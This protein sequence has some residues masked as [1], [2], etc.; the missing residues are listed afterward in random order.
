M[1]HLTR[2]QVVFT[3][4]LFFAWLLLLWLGRSG[5]TTTSTHEASPALT[6]PASAALTK[7]PTPL[8]QPAPLIEVPATGKRVDRRELVQQCLRI[9]ETDVLAAMDFA[10]AQKLAGDDPGLLTAVILRWA[11]H[12]FAEAL[13][14]VQ[15]QP[16]SPA[17]DNTLAHLAFLRAQSDPHAAARIVSQIPAGPI[18]EEA[19][20]S[21]VHQWSRR[22]WEAA[23]FWID[24]LTPENLRLRAITELTI[25]TDRTPGL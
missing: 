3:A 10:V 16:P 22:D 8:A 23:R 1:Q 25:S 6:L 24:G 21:V 2:S 7:R 14:W 19:V 18:H 11:E 9:A 15:A 5:I 13:E 4:P 17:R 20:I 12:D